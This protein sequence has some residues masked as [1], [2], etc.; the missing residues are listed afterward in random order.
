MDFSFYPTS[1]STNGNDAQDPK[2]KR[3]ALLIA[4]FSI[5][6]YLFVACVAFYY[7]RKFSLHTSRDSGMQTLIGKYDHAKQSF[8]RVLFVSCL[9]DIPA[10]VGCLAYDGPTE[11]EW[12]GLD[13]LIF[14]FFHLLALC[15]YAFCIIIPCVLWADMITKKDGKLF[16]SNYPYDCIKRFFQIML[17]LYVCT[18]LLDI[19]MSCIYYRMSDKEA[20][21]D[22]P[23]YDFTP[24]IESILIVSISVGCLYCGIRLQLYVREVK[25]DS[26]IE[27]KFLFTLN[28]IMSILVLSFVSRAV[29][30]LMFIPYIPQSYQQRVSYSVYTI[31]SRWMPDV[32]CQLLLIYI[33]RLSGREVSAK[34]SRY[35][36]SEDSQTEK[37]DVMYSPLLVDDYN[38]DSADLQA[39]IEENLL[40]I[41]KTNENRTTA[42]DSKPSNNTFKYNYKTSDRRFLSSDLDIDEELF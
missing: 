19:I 10:Y 1:S 22:A 14:W 41:F 25:F 6:L 35:V 15:G 16:F 36:N 5:V 40:P 2:L 20:F 26:S 3:E 31:V 13:E 30:V 23:T 9:L 38:Q 17:L 39:S 4:S 33:M 32:F 24:L 42:E 8:F 34:S 7:D 11:C 27:T 12:N 37:K 28:L 18:S 29:L 21:A